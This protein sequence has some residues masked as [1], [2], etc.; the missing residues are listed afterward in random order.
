MG[1]CF[2]FAGLG[3]L[4]GNPI[5]GALLD[6]ESGVFWKAELFS[7]IMVTAGVV[8]FASLRLLKFKEGERGK[9]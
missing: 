5:A 3:L 6:L 8:C 1:M 9:Y 4:I 2:T 7:A